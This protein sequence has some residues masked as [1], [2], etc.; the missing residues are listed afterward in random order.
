[1]FSYNAPVPVAGSGVVH[2]VDPGADGHASFLVTLTRLF[3]QKGT[4]FSW[5]GARGRQ[6][7]GRVHVPSRCAVHLGG[8]EHLFT[9]SVHF[10][11]AW[12]GCVPRYRS[13][14]KVYA[15]A[16]RAGTNPCQIDTE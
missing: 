12:L 9:G 15:R 3:R 1:M 7:T 11:E 13:F 2:R 10:G 6:W 8:E 4:V 16:Q 5:G 14:L